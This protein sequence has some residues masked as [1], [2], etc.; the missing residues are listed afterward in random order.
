M[1]K[2]HYPGD[3]KAN[4]QPSWSLDIAVPGCRELMTIKVTKQMFDEVAS[5]EVFE[6]LVGF[7]TYKEQTY[8]EARGQ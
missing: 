1:G 3:L 8:Y 2:N 6:A 4:R 7:R 5:E